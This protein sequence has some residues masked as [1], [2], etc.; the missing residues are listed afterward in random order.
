M[1]IEIARHAGF[2][3]GVRRAVDQTLNAAE[4]GDEIVTFGELVH[5]PQVI[6]KLEAMTAVCSV[7]IDMVIIPGDTTPA[8]ISALIADEAAIGMVNSKTTAVRVIPAI[9]RKAGE[10][11]DFGGLLGY[12]PI[13]PVNSHDPSVFINRGGRLPAPMQSL[14]N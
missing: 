10:V 3:M 14:K 6:E 4:S 13:M 5:N 12:G 1:G 7:G 2:C 9:G 8:V 11:L